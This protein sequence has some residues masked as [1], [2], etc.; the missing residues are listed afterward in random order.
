M[1]CKLAAFLDDLY[2][3]TRAARARAAL[4]PPARSGPERQRG[5]GPTAGKVGARPPTTG[6]TGDGVG[7]RPPTEVGP[8][9]AL[10]NINLH[11]RKAAAEKLGDQ[12]SKRAGD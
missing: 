6:P 2:I 10:T 5:L 7:A 11:K 3:T 9:Q 12:K 1:R 4:E 8:D